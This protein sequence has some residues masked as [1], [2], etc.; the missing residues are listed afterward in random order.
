MQN[1][2]AS[3]AGLKN[4]T[5]PKVK[6]IKIPSNAPHE[7]YA[8]PPR[9]MQHTKAS[10]K[11]IDAPSTPTK[12]HRVKELD[13]SNLP[14]FMQPTKASQKHTEKKNVLSSPRKVKELDTS[15]LPHYMQPTQ[16]SLK[17]TE[18][19]KEE[20]AKPSTPVK[21]KQPG[22]LSK[23]PRFMQ[24][25]AAY[26]KSIEKEEKQ[27][28]KIPNT[29]RKE[30]EGNDI[31]RFMQQTAATNERLRV[32]EL[33]MKSK[34]EEMKKKQEEMDELDALKAKW[35]SKREKADELMKRG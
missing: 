10:Q 34:Q 26:E 4:Q 24:T 16:T 20:E 32:A 7:T 9:F 12:H 22:S 31:P 8:E 11:H 33:E 27:S 2:R 6:T 21:K 35:E 30:L 14:S 19:E 17:H 3:L 15:T 29:P 13:V 5:T 25:T 18:K 1:T 28:P 23:T